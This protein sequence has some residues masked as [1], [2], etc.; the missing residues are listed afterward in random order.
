MLFKI[1]KNTELF[2]NALI[3]LLKGAQ[4]MGAV[5]RFEI[6]DIE[7]QQLA[8]S[9]QAELS[10]KRIK[11]IVYE[12][13]DYVGENFQVK[14]QRKKS[15]GYVAMPAEE[16]TDTVYFTTGK[17]ATRLFKR[18][19]KR[20]GYVNVAKLS[21]E[22]ATVHVARKTALE[23][24]SGALKLGFLKTDRLAAPEVRPV[25]Y[26]VEALLIA[27]KSIAGRREK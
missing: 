25:D 10:L 5:D 23:G 15:W 4:S 22:K 21:K 16:H 24:L 18:G 26:S 27:S 17:K 14:L 20:M 6:S 12:T 1:D 9:V 11:Q 7:L 13:E 2:K 8:A 19:A 3:N